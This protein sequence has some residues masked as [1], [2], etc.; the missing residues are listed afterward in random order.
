M[1]PHVNI[2][3]SITFFMFRKK[4]FKLNEKIASPFNNKKLSDTILSATLKIL[5][6]IL[7][8]MPVLTISNFIFVYFLF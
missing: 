3:K 7:V 1:L 4:C 8:F 5:F 2:V 6:E